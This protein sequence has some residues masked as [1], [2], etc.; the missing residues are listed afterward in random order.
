MKLGWLTV[1]LVPLGLL[2]AMV[3]PVGCGNSDEGPTQTEEPPYNRESMIQ[4]CARMHSCGV[5]RL[6]HVNTCIHDYESRVAVPAGQAKLYEGLHK[7]VNKAKGDCAKVRKCFGNT[8]DMPECNSGYAAGCDGDVKRWCDTGDKRI[9]AVDCSKGGLK[10]TLDKYGQPFC[11]AG[12]CPSATYSGCSAD[13]KQYLACN[14]KGLQV[15]QCDR[16]GLACGKDSTGN[17]GCVATGKACS[18]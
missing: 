6:T 17:W 1:K 7:C 12:S 4:A 15:E 3:L 14:G 5:F 9:Y 16:I 18:G 13:K 11:G 10:C 8:M 2:A